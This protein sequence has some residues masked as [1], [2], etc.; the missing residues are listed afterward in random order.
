MVTGS[1]SPD[2]DS[3]ISQQERIYIE[4]NTENRDK[5]KVLLPQLPPSM[6]FTDEITL[7]L[8]LYIR[9]YIT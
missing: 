9:T 4:Q 7:L 2:Q 3:S 5:I 8:R 1:N 6:D